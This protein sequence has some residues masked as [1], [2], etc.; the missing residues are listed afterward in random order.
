[1]LNHV[2]CGNICD[3]DSDVSSQAYLA[4]AVFQGRVTNKTK[5]V[6]A[7]IYGRHRYNVTVFVENVF[8]TG[9]ILNVSASAK[10]SLV[11]GIFG[12]VNGSQCVLE[13]KNGSSYIFFLQTRHSWSTY[14]IAS[15]PVHDSESARKAVRKIVCDKCGTQ[16]IQCFNKC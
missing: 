7:R 1:M 9:N 15:A 16:V 3:V 2:I 14:D 12:P 11:V 6:P 8:K 10:T 13:A 5:L 4:K